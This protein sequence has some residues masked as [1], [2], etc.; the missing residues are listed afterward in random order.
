MLIAG[1][2]IAIGASYFAYLN[3]T[4]FPPDLARL[5]P[6]VWLAVAVAGISLGITAIRARRQVYLGVAGILLG[7]PSVAFA[8]IF[9][10]A[11]AMGG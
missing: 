11:A 4:S 10:M 9:A 3:A 5:I 1:A 8:A 2:S 7:L 6:L